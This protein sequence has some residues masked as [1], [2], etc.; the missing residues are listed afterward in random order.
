M[1]GEE[2]D[3][4]IVVL[5][6]F[7]WSSGDGDLKHAYWVKPYVLIFLHLGTGLSISRLASSLVK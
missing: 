2:C 6:L 5:H 7:S 4:I 3:Q 1:S